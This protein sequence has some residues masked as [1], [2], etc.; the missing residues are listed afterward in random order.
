MKT[1]LLLFLLLFLLPFAVKAEI[2]NIDNNQL[3][4]LIAQKV[5][6]IDIRTAPEWAETGVL[7]GSHLL[8]F[9]DADGN[10]D[11]RSWL[12]ELAP[13]A[14]K[15]DPVILI[16]RTGHRTGLVSKLMVDQAGYGTVYNVTKGIRN[17]I[18]QGNPTVAPK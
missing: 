7:E 14:G 15:D 13:V 10:S 8:T 1:K 5:P 16:C 9:F 4:E 12:A 2:I 11:A 17:W 6:V 3:K 18:E